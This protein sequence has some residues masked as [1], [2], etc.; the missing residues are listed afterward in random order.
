MNGNSVAENHSLSNG[1][2]KLFELLDGAQGD[3][4]EVIPEV[5]DRKRIAGDPTR[6]VEDRLEA[7]EDVF[8]SEVGDTPL[9]RARNLEREVGIRQLFLKFEGAN[10]T[11]TQKDRIAFAQVMDALRRGFDT[12]TMATCGNYGAAVAL[13]ASVAGLRC[14]VCIPES[15]HTRRVK[16][17][18]DLGAEIVRVPGDYESAVEMS[19]ELAA[20]NEYYD[21]N[22]GSANTS[23][24][25]RAYGEIAYEIYD[26]LRDAPAVVAVPVSNGTTLA[27]IYK[28][29]VSLYR[30]GKTSRVPR[31]VAG[32]SYRKNPIVQAF[33]RRAPSCLDLRPQ[34][35]RETSIN[36]PLVNWHSI[37]GD[38]ALAAIRNTRGWAAN[39]TD[40]SMLAFSKL[41]REKEGLHVLPASTAGLIALLDLHSHEP[42][43]G[44]RYVVVL[45]G[46]R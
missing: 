3:F 22:P 19:R 24:Q 2:A 45:T 38:L 20:Q 28:G 29:F 26:E 36:E 16:E 40:K 27:G 35:I 9:T 44:D 39:A 5:E 42:L 17:I 8:E 23:L 12:I 37:D 11:G 13:A 18:I 4:L 31:V 46:R 32:S 10:P 33:L 14:I 25:L 30:R 34:L 41:L 15:Y 43:P 7:L 1:D 6:P 21:A